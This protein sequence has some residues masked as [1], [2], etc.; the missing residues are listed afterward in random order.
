[1]QKLLLSI[2]FSHGI[3]ITEV[4]NR[5]ATI[6]Q[7]TSKD[8]AR[9]KILI[10]EDDS[11]ML[12]ALMLLLKSEM[13]DLTEAQNGK[14]AFQKISRESFDLIITDLFLNGM[15][16]LDIFKKF[17]N[18]IPV[19]IMTGYVDSELAQDAKKEAG[20]DFVEKPFSPQFFRKKVKNLLSKNE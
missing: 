15:T 19:L 6:F 7:M 17:K 4:G 5:Y 18:K 16:G 1:L 2:V 8:R 11:T 14:Q 9:K 20:E 10:I 3:Q 13:H 12:K